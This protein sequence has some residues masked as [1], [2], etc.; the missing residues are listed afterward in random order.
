MGGACPNLR[1]SHIC[2]TASDSAFN[3]TTLAC[4]LIIFCSTDTVSSASKY[5]GEKKEK[6]DQCYVLDYSVEVAV[7][8]QLCEN[9]KETE[10]EVG[11][12]GKGANK[13]MKEREYLGMMRQEELEHGTGG[14]TLST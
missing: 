9:M 13:Y 8:V 5:I 11:G 2:D 4:V 14:T 7:F 6:E 3:F 12:A 10:E 1:F